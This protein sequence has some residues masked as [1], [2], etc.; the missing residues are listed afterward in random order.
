[1]R[2]G[3]W[4]QQLS[5]NEGGSDAEG[6]RDTVTVTGLRVRGRNRDGQ[7]GCTDLRQYT[8]AARATHPRVKLKIMAVPD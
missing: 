4:K 3:I 6:P 1:M 5:E 7:H 2:Q 8:K